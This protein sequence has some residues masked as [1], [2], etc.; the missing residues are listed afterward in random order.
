MNQPLRK[1]WEE[2]YPL[3][4]KAAPGRRPRPKKSFNLSRSRIPALIG[5]FLLAYMA[6]SFYGQ[7]NK[8]AN[9]RKDV[10]NIQQQVQD[11]QQK[12]ATLREELR[13]VQSDAYI[14][15]TA[16]E[17]IGLIKPGE[18]RVI[19]VE[20]GTQVKG[21]QSPSSQNVVAD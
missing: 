11:L 5:V 9:M 15:K 14:E 13:M 1:E 8:L 18:T 10:S 2:F 7:F 17:K 21:I 16:R 6:F 19:P 20:P 3:E 4:K 12:N